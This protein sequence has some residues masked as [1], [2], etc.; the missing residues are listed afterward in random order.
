M[1]RKYS[2]CDFVLFLGKSMVMVNMIQE[3]NRGMMCILNGGNATQPS[4]HLPGN[5]SHIKR[6]TAHYYY[7]F[8]SDPCNNWTSAVDTAKESRS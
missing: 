5:E 2:W 8:L 6:D 4:F 7:T 3:E 1:K